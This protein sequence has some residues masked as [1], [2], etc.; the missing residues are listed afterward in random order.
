MRRRAVHEEDD[1][2]WGRWAFAIADLAQEAKERMSWMEQN[3]PE[4]LEEQERQE[5]REQLLRQ[6]AED[7]A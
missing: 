2:D 1:P 7:D 4:V 5:L 6:Q 3:A